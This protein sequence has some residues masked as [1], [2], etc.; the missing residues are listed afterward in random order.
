M[1]VEFVTIQQ[2]QQFMESI[3]DHS[4]FQLPIW[5]QVLEKTYPACKI[6]TRL[7]TFDN[8]VQVLLPL[9]KTTNKLGFELLESLPRGCYGGFLWNKRPSEEQICQILELI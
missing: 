4:F 2:W 5:S 3:P 7:F 8:D 6:A 1:L 9:V